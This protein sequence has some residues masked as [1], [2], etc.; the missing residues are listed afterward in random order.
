MKSKNSEGIVITDK[1]VQQQLIHCWNNIN[2]ENNNSEFYWSKSW[3]I[4]PPNKIKVNS[5]NVD[6]IISTQ[7]SSYFRRKD[8]FGNTVGQVQIEYNKMGAC[9][10]WD[11]LN[12]NNFINRQVTVLPLNYT[13][14]LVFNP[15]TIRVV[16]VNS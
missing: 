4:T 6:N 12:M 11:I 16:L 13:Q 10:V 1:A 5:G 3:K 8:E 15:F 14:K 9:N 7:A 2:E